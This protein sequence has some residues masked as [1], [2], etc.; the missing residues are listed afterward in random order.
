MKISHVL[1]LFSLIFLQFGCSSTK[2]N[3]LQET[4][5]SDNQKIKIVMSNPEGFELQIIY[6]QIL[7]DKNNNVSFKDFTYH[8]NAENYFYP[9]STIKF[10]IAILA[11]EK[12][13][14]IENTE[15]NSEFTIEG[16]SNKLKFS[17]EISKIFAVS[18]NEASTN[19]LEF[20]GLDDINKSM[21]AKG[22]EPFRLSHRVS[23]SDPRS[24][25]TK[26]ITLYKTDGILSVV[27]LVL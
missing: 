20:L 15:V 19:L 16:N 1:M 4:L 3:I 9:A 10:P 2:K 11:L 18:E 7:H 25:A 5:A 21:K 14:S 17:E 24:L 6:T 27:P 13:N 23:G 12:L 26:P 8:L 22:L